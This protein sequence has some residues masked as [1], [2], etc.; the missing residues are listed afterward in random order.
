MA[1]QTGGFVTRKRPD[2]IVT[3]V[4]SYVSYLPDGDSIASVASVVAGED[5]SDLTVVSTA[6]D[7]PDVAC[8]LSGGTPEGIYQVYLTATFAGGLK[9]TLQF[10]VDVERADG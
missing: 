2:D 4:V 8:R 10:E 5:D 1:K 9:R 7:G 3:W 6:I